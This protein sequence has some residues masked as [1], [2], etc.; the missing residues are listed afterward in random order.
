MANDSDA[1]LNGRV[2]FGIADDGNNIGDAF[3]IGC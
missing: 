3:S 2:H 1:G